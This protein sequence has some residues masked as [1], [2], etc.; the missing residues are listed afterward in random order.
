M[1]QYFRKASI[2]SKSKGRIFEGLRVPFKLLFKYLT[3]RVTMFK[4][5]TNIVTMFKYLTNRVTMFKIL[6]EQSNNL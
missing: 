2:K 1:F 3:N 5:L 6:N 4:Y